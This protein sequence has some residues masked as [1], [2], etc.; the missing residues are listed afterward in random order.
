LYSGDTAA[1]MLTAFGL[2]G[3]AFKQVCALIAKGGL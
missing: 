2:A 1:K 3:A